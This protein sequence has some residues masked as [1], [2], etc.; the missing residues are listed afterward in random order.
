MKKSELLSFINRYYLNGN[1][2][3]VK[4][5]E[6]T[7]SVSCNLIDED[8]TVVGKV[9]WKT[10]PFVK[11]NMGVNHTGTLIKMLS[12]IDEEL[13]FIV[14]QSGNQNY[15]VEIKQGSTKLTF[16]L[17]DINVIPAVPQIND[18]PEYEVE[19]DINDEFI[20]KFIKA[21]NALPESKNFAVQV[22]DNQIKFIIN[23]S[24]INTDNISFELPGG[25][26]PMS[27]I[28]FSA[29]KLKEILTVNKGDSGKLYVSS[30]GLSKVDF[31]SEKFESTY[32][33]V[34]LQN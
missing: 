8:Q 23:Y 29:D 10:D 21:K 24:T 25:T 30:A 1:V 2:E 5:S 34:Q 6:G 33:L 9:T 14:K 19:L 13:D 12:A 3:A 18:E 15:C 22:K 20:N 26:A 16:M 4:V 17:A 7:D 11:G 28:L 32:F 27:P 31:K